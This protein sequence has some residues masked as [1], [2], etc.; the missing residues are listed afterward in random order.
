MPINRPIRKLTALVLAGV[1]VA[2]AAE[3]GTQ[4]VAAQSGARPAITANQGNPKAVPPILR[5]AR[6]SELVEIRVAEA[7]DGQ[8]LY[9][10]PPASARYSGAAFSVFAK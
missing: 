2:V 10:D 1:A 9:Y 7:R 6:P 4:S 5:A 3:T 8:E